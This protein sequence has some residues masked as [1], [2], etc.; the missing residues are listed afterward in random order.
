M[1]F[2]KA[3]IKI[4]F[5]TFIAVFL[6]VTLQHLGL[7]IP[8]IISPLAKKDDI[9]EMIIRP[10]IEYKEN[11]YKIS[12]PNQ[13][14]RKAHASQSFDEA[15]SYA[16]VDYD[17]G[18]II[19]SKNQD[20][21]LPIASLTKIMTAVVALDLADPSEEFSVTENAASEIPT[22]IGVTPKEKLTLNELLHAALMTSANDA[23]EVIKDGIDTKYGHPVFMK[24]MNEK[25]AFLGLS[26]THFT[27]PQGF[28]NP[29]HHSSV[30]DLVILTHYALT[31]YPLITD[32]VK[33]D[34]TLLAENSKH[35]QFL[36]YNWNGLIDVYPGAFGV[37]IGNTD[38]AGKTTIVAS[39]REGKRMIAA[40]LGA[41]NIKK[42]D[43]WAADLLDM[44]FYE[45]YGMQPVEVRESQLMEKYATWKY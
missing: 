17:T 14:I 30:G 6:M 33:K 37:K 23:V 32:I 25:A 27:N 20:E 9:F 5:I 38:E 4:F 44:G 31:N 36:L 26:H 28:D 43:L 7:R 1:L 2:T 3:H 24:A 42:R 22:K 10:K 45:A 41:P 15:S 19:A 8:N 11:F 12:S 40:V 29:E 21:P 34:Q 35:G 39:E 13:L 16:V 18:T